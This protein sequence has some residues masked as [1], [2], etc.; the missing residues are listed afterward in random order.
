MSSSS[1]RDT[2]RHDAVAPYTVSPT[3]REAV[4]H[5]EAEDSGLQRWSIGVVSDAPS[6]QVFMTVCL[7]AEFDVTAADTLRRLAALGRE[8][9]LRLLVADLHTLEHEERDLH[10]LFESF[11]G[12]P[13]LV[14]SQQPGRSAFLRGD[15]RLHSAQVVSIPAPA[16]EIREVAWEMVRTAGAV[17]SPDDYRAD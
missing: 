8:K 10:V 15:E 2:D 3:V 6:L 16:S 14:L 12:V 1:P 7:R 17:N 4:A 9:A 11:P 5:L 13:L